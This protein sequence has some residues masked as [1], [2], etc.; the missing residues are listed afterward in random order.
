MK[1]MAPSKAWR[2]NEF[3]VTQYLLTCGWLSSLLYAVT[4]VL[5][6]MSYK[7]YSFSSQAVSELMAI[8]AP[9][10]PI[11]DPMFLLGGLLGMAFGV[12]IVRAA[13]GRRPLRMAGILLTLYAA[14]GLTGPTLFEMHPR[15]SGA[16]GADLP[17][18][19]VT[20]ILVMLTLAIISFAAAG[21]GRRFRWY[22]LATLLT[23]LTFGIL[24]APFGSHL[25]TGESTEG[26]GIIERV[27]IYAAQLWIAVLA[28]VLIRQEHARGGQISVRPAAPIAGFVAP[29]FEEVRAEFERN[30]SER[31]EIGA[32][33][34]AYW[35]GR[36][37]VDLWGGRR[38]PRS[39]EPWL[40][41]TM[42]PVMSATKGLAA[43]TLA[44]ADA[45]GWL[46]YDAPVA[47]YW[48]EFAQ[49]GKEQITIR[50]LLG[51]EAGLVLLDEELTLEK[52]E[53]LDYMAAMLA[54]QRPAW[55]PGTRHGY[56]T[57]TIGLYMQE[58]IRR[59][60]PLHRS[61]GHFFHDEIAVPLRLQ[62]YIG[63]P[64]QVSSD[65]IATLKTLSR[66]RALLAIRN[67]PAVLIRKILL[68][69][70]L[71]RKSMLIADLDFND[72]RTLEV[73]LPAGNGVGTA[74]SIARAYSAFAS[75]GSEVGIT[76]ST[77]SRIMQPPA[78]ENPIDE[79]LGV[80]S[81][82]SLGFMRPGPD[83]MFGSSARAFGTPGAGGSFGFADP[84]TRLGYAYV[85]NKMDFHLVDDPREKS[86]RD[87]IYRAM[88][89]L[90]SDWN[91]P[92]SRPDRIAAM[93]RN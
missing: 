33:V 20:A 47:R 6:G 46:D 1:R 42:V 86:L 92:S 84:D 45:Q 55:R 73:E 75:G 32:A 13:N 85:M 9:S 4:D 16:L 17:H 3:A 7:G 87:A 11:V 58:I 81:Y 77:F 23:I 12:G 21:L 62:F 43:M 19:I 24:A 14:I 44:V 78:P 59:V 60:D 38:S 41:N 27:L 70:S 64:Q 10:E 28:L 61:L 68:P 25:I 29:G 79:L 67:T 26:F 65:R 91:L 34:A 71:L 40:E 22:S 80:P 52:L 56:H 31:G 18:I 76:P 57:M 51:H 48:P 37:I 88:R 50:Q 53:D 8:G 89:R 49:N 90:P 93:L 15:G 2:G 5:G 83:V 30:F 69:N 74:R 72:R 82:F 39:G 35:H 54:R 36:K 66:G 63:I